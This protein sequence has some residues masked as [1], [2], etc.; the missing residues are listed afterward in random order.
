MYLFYCMKKKN[1]KEYAMVGILKSI[2]ATGY[3]WVTNVDNS[4]LG[5]FNI[6]DDLQTDKNKKNKFNPTHWCEIEVPKEE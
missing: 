3:H 2:D 4:L 1:G 5:I 6:F